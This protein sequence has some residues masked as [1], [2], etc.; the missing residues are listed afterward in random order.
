MTPYTPN[1]VI[2][3][4]KKDR[5]HKEDAKKFPTYSIRIDLFRRYGRDNIRPGL[6]ELVKTEQIIMGRT[7]NDYYFELKE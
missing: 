2:D 4:L 7:V 6:V 5:K 1:E 3:I